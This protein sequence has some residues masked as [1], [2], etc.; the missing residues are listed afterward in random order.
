MVGMGSA[1]AINTGDGV[2]A[3]ARVA[4][5]E[6]ENFDKNNLSKNQLLYA[7]RFR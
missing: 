3:M 5:F 1:Q 6:Q 4:I 2:H 7:L